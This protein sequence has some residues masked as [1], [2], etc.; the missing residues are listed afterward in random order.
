[1]LNNENPSDVSPFVLLSI[2]LAAAY[3]M[4]LFGKRTIRVLFWTVAVVLV[5]VFISGTVHGFSLMQRIN[6]I[7]FVFIYLLLLYFIFEEETL[8]LRRQ[9][10]GLTAQAAELRPFAELGTNIAG[11]VH[12]F[13]NDVAGVSAIASIERLSE[14]GELAGKLQ[15]YA[16][17]LNNRIERILYVATA[18]DHYELEEIRIDEM[19]EKVVYYFVEINQTLKHA[20]AIH[21][22]APVPITVRTRRNLI[23]TILENVIKNSVE[24]TDGQASRSVWISAHVLDGT[25]ELTVEHNGRPLS[26]G[27]A[28]STPVDVRRSTYFRRGKSDRTGGTGLGMINVIRALEILDAEMTM[29]NRS[30]GVRTVLRH[31]DVVSE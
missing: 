25:L 30:P 8:S 28:G 17:R 23:M 15:H 24:A 2:A 6:L 29:E 21:L 5:V 9:R 22:D 10:D 20:V 31:G 18:G 27:I 11:L 1:V 13:R 12:D 14:N 4:S 26:P 16:D 19:L 7:N 3:K